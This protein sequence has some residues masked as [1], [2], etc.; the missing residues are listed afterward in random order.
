MSVDRINRAVRNNAEWCEIVCALHGNSGTFVD[1]MWM[2]R[3][4]VPRFYPNVQTLA[5][6]APGQIKLIE[7]LIRLRLPIGW[8]VKDS[9]ASLNLA[10]L[11]FTLLF[12]AQWIFLAQEKVRSLASAAPRWETLRFENAVA[13]WESAWRDANGDTNT[14]RIFLRELL[15]NPDVAIVAGYRDEHIVAGAIGNRSSGVVGWSNFF[16]VRGE[17]TRV[18]AAGSLAQISRNFPDTAI[19]G[20]EEGEMLRLAESLGF[21][22]LGPLRVWLFDGR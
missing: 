18:C 6:E 15:D 3:G 14:A 4:R 5:R 19:V 21:E 22:A 7:E 11:G 9:F 12:E 13:Q 16:A 17:D 20:Y 2:N 8:A 10:P 1:A